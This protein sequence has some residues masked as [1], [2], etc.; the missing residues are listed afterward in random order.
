MIGDSVV[1]VLPAAGL[2]SRLRPFRYPKELLP[3]AYEVE[4]EDA[5]A[6]RPRA[7]VEY[8]VAALVRAGVPRCVAVV[9]PWKLDVVRYLGGGEDLGISMSY[10][11]QEEARGLPWAVDLAYPWTGGCDV[12][13][14]LPDT[15]IRPPDFLATTLRRHQESGADLTLAVFPT[16]E[17][18]RLGPVVHQG[19]VVTAVVDKPARAPADNTWGAAVWGPAFSELLHLAVVESPADAGEM[20]LGNCFQAAV[21]KGLDVRAVD[22]DGSF[23]D[24]GTPR[25]LGTVLA[26]GHPVGGAR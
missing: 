12:V 24:V 15:V 6:L 25:G 4:G 16:T 1:G 9:A 3:V 7:V 22:V 13:M 5:G 8:S 14:V 17:P 20:P 10:V 2:A 19:G 26:A 23:C 11:L 18:Q 21:D